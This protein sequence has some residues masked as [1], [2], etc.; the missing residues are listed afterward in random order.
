[1]K[2]R[3]LLGALAIGFVVFLLAA[4]FRF[5]LEAN[6]D[7]ER[8]LFRTWALLHGEWPEKTPRIDH[9]PLGLG[10]AWYVLT[11]PILAAADGDARAVHLAHVGWLA[12]GFIAV[13]LALGRRLDAETVAAFILL[14]GTSSFLS[15]VMVRVW[16]P[17]LF[18]AAALGWFALMAVAVDGSSARRRAW[19]LVA[20]WLIMPLMLQLHL[21]A[22]PY[23]VVLTAASVV[24]FRRD[25]TTGGRTPVALVVMAA[26]AIAAWWGSKLAGLDLEQAR[27]LSADRM[28]RENA[29]VAALAEL[30]QFFSSAWAAPWARWIGLGTLGLAG[31]GAVRAVRR[32]RGRWTIDQWALLQVV[33]GLP[34]VLV[35]GRLA[36]QARYFSGIV[37]G[38]YVLAALGLAPWMRRIPLRWRPGVVAALAV[39]LIAGGWMR[40]PAPAGEEPQTLGELTLHEQTQFAEWA[41]ARGLD[42]SALAQRAHG[43]LYGG[44]SAIRWV[45]YSVALGVPRGPAGPGDVWVGPL[46]FPEPALTT[47]RDVIQEPGTRPLVVATVPRRVDAMRTAA[48]V[49]DVPCPIAIPYRWGP[50]TATEYAAF[51]V[52][53][54]LELEHCRR[55]RSAPLVLDVETSGAGPLHL[56]VGWFDIAAQYQR[57]AE[58]SVQDRSG[59][60]VRLTRLEG[61]MLKNLAVFRFM[62]PNDGFRMSIGPL[63]TIA[64][65]DLY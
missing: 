5:Q 25:R 62:P 4:P 57:R 55:D 59:R 23:G 65:V 37:P 24:V 40:W 49:G 14:F 13:G 54:A 34:V 6:A 3:L 44:L 21:V 8:D 31:I 61:E 11:A 46:G 30:P 16:H 27:Q 50:L 20:A 63:D 33:I 10:P 51:G 58:V 26:L 35:M 60:T 17:A 39:G 28:T 2:R 48:R 52:R 64:V 1:V 38:I 29:T 45:G 47:T 7:T 19:S 53:H 32:A 18:P 22:A 43:S 41:L 9:S 56:V 36:P 12:V 42:A 15:Q